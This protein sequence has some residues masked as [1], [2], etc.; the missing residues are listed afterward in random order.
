MRCNNER[1]WT[2]W[3]FVIVKHNLMLVFHASVLLLTMSFA[4]WIHCLCDYVMM[5]FMINNK[6]GAWETDFNLLNGPLHKKFC[7]Q[8]LRTRDDITALQ[9]YVEFFRKQFQCIQLEWEGQ[10]RNACKAIKEFLRGYKWL[11]ELMDGGGGPWEGK[12]GCN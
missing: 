1:E 7:M 11:M 2:I 4:S 12:C 5:K 3:Q 8:L 6:T 10:M 9:G